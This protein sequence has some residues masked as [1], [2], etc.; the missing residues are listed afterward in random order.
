M[1]T[2]F[3]ELHAQA[4]NR[5]RF[6]QNERE[7]LGRLF[8][9]RTDWNLMK[10]T[11]LEQTTKQQMYLIADNEIPTEQLYHDLSLTKENH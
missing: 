2:K 4:L 8:A 1:N 10:F 6:W 5:K 9:P 3:A 7:S 11:R